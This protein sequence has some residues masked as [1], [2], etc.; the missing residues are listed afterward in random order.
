[1]YLSVCLSIIYESII[2]LVLMIWTH[3]VWGAVLWVDSWFTV[4]L[5]PW[6]PCF[7][8]PWQPAPWKVFLVEGKE[9]LCH[10]HHHGGSWA[11]SP[12]TGCAPPWEA[13]LSAPPVLG[14]GTA[15][16]GPQGLLRNWL[17]LNHPLWFRFS[18]GTVMVSDG[19]PRSVLG[20]KAQRDKGRWGPDTEP[21]V[22]R[23][24]REGSF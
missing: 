10:L 18:D 5:G 22:G 6:K 3:R 24:C 13:L 4:L 14:V 21:R 2:Y 19:F 8:A 15:P 9:H 11:G 7:Q 23:G 16:C 12:T 20:P 1:M 17:C